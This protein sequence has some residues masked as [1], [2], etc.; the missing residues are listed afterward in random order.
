MD[1]QK[2]R[3]FV[4]SLGF[5]SWYEHN[6]SCLPCLEVHQ[7]MMVEV[8]MISVLTALQWKI[9]S[10]LFDIILFG[11]N[12]KIVPFIESWSYISQRQQA[13]LFFVYFDEMNF[14]SSSSLSLT[15]DWMC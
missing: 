9:R 13:I 11:T 8:M 12:M 10:I 4:D 1:K 14:F 6:R 7:V 3:K 5:I 15:E 2:K